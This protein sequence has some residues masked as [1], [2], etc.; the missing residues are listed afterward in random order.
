MLEDDKTGRALR[1]LGSGEQLQML[2]KWNP[3]YDSQQ[4]P[5]RTIT[6]GDQITGWVGSTAALFVERASYRSGIPGCEYWIGQL[7]GLPSLCSVQRVTSAPNASGGQTKSTSIVAASVPC[8]VV[9]GSGTVA[10][11]E[12]RLTALSKWQITVP[13]G[14]PVTNSDQL[15]VGSVV[16]S[17]NAILQDTNAVAY[18]TIVLCDRVQ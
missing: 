9:A 14:T 11:G 4:R 6:E 17:V 13:L 1:L 10:I 16:Y 15:L 18:A 2:L 7:I 8:S 12:E 5:I 3:A